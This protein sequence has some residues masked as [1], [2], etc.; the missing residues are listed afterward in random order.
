[1][2]TEALRRYVIDK[3]SKLLKKIGLTNTVGGTHTKICIDNSTYTTV[4]TDNTY[5]VV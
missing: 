3:E 5:F 4:V 2:G 1:M